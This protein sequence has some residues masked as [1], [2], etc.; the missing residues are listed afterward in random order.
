[1]SSFDVFKA[2]ADALGLEGAELGQYILQQ[3]AIERDQRAAEREKRSG[4]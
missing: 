3:Q 4:S 2:Q 1:M